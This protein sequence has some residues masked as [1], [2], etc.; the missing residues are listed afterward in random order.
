LEVKEVVFGE[1]KKL[2]ELKELKTIPSRR[3]IVFMLFRSQEVKA[4]A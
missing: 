2:K 4:K 3:V 1:L